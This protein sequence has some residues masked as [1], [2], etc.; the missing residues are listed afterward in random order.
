MMLGGREERG[1]KWV[2]G[3]WLGRENFGRVGVDMRLIESA[4][5]I[6]RFGGVDC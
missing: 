1:V 5:M 6:R 2:S 3:Q 4:G